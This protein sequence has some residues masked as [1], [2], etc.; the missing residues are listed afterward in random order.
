M[1][2]MLKVIKTKQIKKYETMMAGVEG[3]ERKSDIRTL[4]ERIDKDTTPVVIYEGTVISD[5]DI[6]FP[7]V[8]PRSMERIEES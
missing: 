2:K 1:F 8:P 4:K 5:K 3:R 6:N 7:G